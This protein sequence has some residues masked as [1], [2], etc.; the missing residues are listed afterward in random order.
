MKRL[1]IATFA[2]V[3]TLAAWGA[4]DLSDLRGLVLTHA[5]LPVYNKQNLQVMVFCDKAER[6]G[7]MMVGYDVVLDLIRR[8]ADVDSIRNGWGLK[9]YPLDAKLPEI[10]AFWSERPY[11]DGVILTSRANVDQ[12]TRM[13]DGDESVFFRSP[14]MDLNGIGFEADFDKR[15]VLV[16]ED[17]KIVVRMEGSDPRRIRAA[18]GKLPAKYEF[19]TATAD[20]MRIDM[21]ANQVLLVGSVVIDEANSVVTCDRMTIFLDRRSDAELKAANDRGALGSGSDMGG[22][23]RVLCDGNVVITRKLS[24]EE[25]AKNGAQQALADHLVYDP[26][27]GTVILTGDKRLPVVKRGTESLS[28]ETMTLHRNEQRAVINGKGKVVAFQPPQKPGEEGTRVTIASDAVQLDYLRNYGE[29][30]GN[31]VVDD[32]RMQLKCARMR[33]DLKELAQQKAELPAEAAA[34]LSGMPDFDA[35]SRRE[36]DKITCSGGVEVVRRDA[37]GKLLPGEKGTSE[38]AVFD[39]LSKNITMTGNSPTLKRDNDSLSGG[40]LVIWID[41]ERVCTHNGSK[42]VLGARSAGA[43]QSGKSSETIILSDSSDLNYGGNLL[44]FNRNVKVNDERM[45]LDCDR[46]EIHLIG[47]P[48]A[49]NAEKNAVDVLAL[50]DPGRSDRTLSRVVCTG[51]V[52]ALDQ[53]SDMRCDTFT[54]HFAPQPPGVTTPGMFQSNGT[55]LVR[56][57]ADGNFEA[58]NKPAPGEGEKVAQNS[59]LGGLMRNSSGKPRRISAER[60]QVDFR[61]NL[62]EFH[63]NVYVRD[64]ENSLKCDDMYLYAG[65]S[66]AVPAKGGAA[67]PRQPNL[68]DDPFAL[69]EA[70]T[71]PARISL[72]DEL[73]LQRVLCRNNVLFVRRTSTGELQRAGGNEADYVVANREMIVTGK[74]GEKPWMSAEGR[75]LYSDRIIV[76]VVTETMRGENGTATTEKSTNF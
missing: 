55:E 5:K 63:G 75:R 6:S 68:D 8:G 24:K 64:E 45:K 9:A 60:G 76:D 69:E 34:T 70:E 20:S 72:T 23:S 2:G 18:G 7:R 50:D 37:A 41:E 65:K 29:F 14:L 59:D 15:T 35:G 17:V 48:S 26:A 16:K 32:P 22:V 54:M 12:E 51:N 33:I 42:V 19:V 25:I 27:A 10:L 73:D 57:N 30:I 53:G 61:K 62:T 4:G 1:M 58:V 44:T 74:P 21:A 31:V 36:L 66:P 56:I 13:A 11:S 67:A 71:V 39:Y 49:E 3:L 46:M 38:N 52:H 28:G 47:K 43:G 40:E